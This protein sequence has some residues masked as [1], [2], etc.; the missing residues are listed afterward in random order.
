MGLPNYITFS[1]LFITPIFMILYLKGKWFGITP[2]VLP[3]VLLALLAISELTDAIDGYVA[4]KFSQVT[5]LGKLLDPMADSIY[6]ISIYLT[7]TQPPVNLPLLL[8]FIFLARDSV[9][10]TLRTVCAFRGRVVAARAS[11]KLKAI[12]QGVSFFLILLVM[13]PHSLG[14]LSQNGLEIFASVT[15]SIIAVYS[16]A[17]GIEY[18]WMN[19]NFLSQRAKT[20]DSEKNHE[21]KD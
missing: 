2:V 12:L 7:F 14:L 5:D 21:S 15:V 4:R 6:R 18:F 9:I 13:I 8:V 1:R 11:G 16:I 17:S 3:Y 20:K 19:K 10:S